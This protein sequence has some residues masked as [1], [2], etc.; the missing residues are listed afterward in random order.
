M[1]SSRRIIPHNECLSRIGPRQPGRDAD[2]LRPIY[3][4]ET[5]REAGYGEA[6]MGRSVSSTV[7]GTKSYSRTSS[8][9]GT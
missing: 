2:Q 3:S 4:L 1:F 6:D 7:S 8:R 9:F 5:R